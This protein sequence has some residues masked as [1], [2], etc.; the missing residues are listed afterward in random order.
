MKTLIRLLNELR[1]SGPEKIIDDRYNKFRK[2]GR[3]V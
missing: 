1:T 3:W 2:M